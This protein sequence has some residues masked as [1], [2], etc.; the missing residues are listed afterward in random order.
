[1][2]FRIKRLRISSGGPNIA[3]LHKEDALKLGVHKGDRILLKAGRRE[4][5]AVVDFSEGDNIIK[6]GLMGVNEEV[7][8]NLKSPGSVNASLIVKP[9]SLHYIKKKLNGNELNEDEMLQIVQDIVDNKII[10]FEISFFVG[11][12]YMHGFT[13]KETIGL[14]K[15][16]IK[17]GEVLDFGKNAY[18][19]HC[20]GGV[21]NNRTTMIIVPI[22]A[23]AGLKIPK[24][25]SRS[26]TSPAGTA[27][28][29]EVLANVN[30]DIAKIK[31]IV[32]KQN[33]CIVWGGSIRLAPADDKIINVEHPLSI[34]AEGQL[35]SSVLAKKASVSA[36]KVLIDIPLGR[37]TK[38]KTQKQADS[39]KRR[40]ESVAKAI[41]M[42]LN[43]IIS[44]GNEPVGNGL[45]PSLEAR[46]VLWILENDKRAPKDL[47][48]KSLHMAGLI[49]EMSGK[50]SKGEGYEHARHIL[51]SGKALSKMKEIINAQG[52]K[53]DSSSEI[54]EGK[55]SF[56]IKAKKKGKLRNY[57]TA[58]LSVF[59]QLLGAPQDKRAGLYLY[60]KKGD[61]VDAGDKIMTAYADNL[62]KLKLG[63]SFYND[64]H[65]EIYQL[66]Q[67]KI[68]E[69]VKK[70]SLKTKKKA[71]LKR[72]SK[73]KKAEYSGSKK[74]S[75][76]KKK[77]KL[78][79][80]KTARK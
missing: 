58:L 35:V 68:K 16:M 3:Y 18:D 32:E 20:T 72:S 56:D 78:S 15:A 44:D 64:R 79:T 48:E 25:S 14:T 42:K 11:A 8:K 9:I 36:R 24:T 73:P 30:L 52:K 5:A 67:G 53:I 22:I 77:K 37:E 57:N 80:K 29:M 76:S 4:T 47:E 50:H 45:G 7:Y 62:E 12:G 13:D 41:G 27:D 10:D 21:P 59:A 66:H 2:D 63:H 60:K 6:K 33:G 34:D 38:I 46:D 74:A 26:I 39:L 69:A 31:K 43:V 70:K 65:Q 1:M 61:S 19:K 17:T 51:K 75:N 40:F 54:K 23:A 49:L 55:Y 28:T 71:A